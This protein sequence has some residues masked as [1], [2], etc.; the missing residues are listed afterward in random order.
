MRTWPS[1]IGRLRPRVWTGVKSQIIC[2]RELA[3]CEW[4]RWRQDY[5][6][7]ERLSVFLRKER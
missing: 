4:N 2:E 6:R 3:I 5:E 1:C 7:A